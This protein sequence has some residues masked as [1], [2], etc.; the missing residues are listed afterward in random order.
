MTRVKQDETGEQGK[1]YHC[2]GL[3]AARP[4][5]NRQIELEE[6]EPQGPDAGGRRTLSIEKG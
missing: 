1:G 6:V 2:K 3:S 5:Q 4:I